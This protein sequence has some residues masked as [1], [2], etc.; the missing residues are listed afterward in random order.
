MITKRNEVLSPCSLINVALC[1]QN[2]LARLMC[3]S[4]CE[5]LSAY[6]KYRL[7]AAR[8]AGKDYGRT[9]LGDLHRPDGLVV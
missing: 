8:D 4:E 2:M 1:C 3:R 7:H 9:Y 6:A 5:R